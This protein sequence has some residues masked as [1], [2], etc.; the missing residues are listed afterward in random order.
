MSLQA[1]QL[2]RGEP[3]LHRSWAGETVLFDPES[4]DTHLLD[5]ASFGV[6]TCLDDGPLTLEELSQRV[7]T[8]LDIPHDRQLLSYVSEVIGR[9]SDKGLVELVHLPGTL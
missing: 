4:G 7:A 5:E 8:Y 3:F 6:F 9:L 2:R 1:W